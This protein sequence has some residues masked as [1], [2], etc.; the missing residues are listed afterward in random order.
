[1]VLLQFLNQL[2]NQSAR[3][4]TDTVQSLEEANHSLTRSL[5]KE[6]RNFDTMEAIHKSSVYMRQ[7]V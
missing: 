4:L 7:Q 1:M 5:G 3:T 2:Q 6:N